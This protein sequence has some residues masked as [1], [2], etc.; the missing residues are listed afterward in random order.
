MMIAGLSDSLAAIPGRASPQPGPAAPQEGDR[1]PVRG[2]DLHPR[3]SV[4][5]PASA[6]SP[7][8]RAHLPQSSPLLSSRPYW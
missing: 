4:Y 6:C 2:P 1:A 3:Q 5:I 7:G 8:T